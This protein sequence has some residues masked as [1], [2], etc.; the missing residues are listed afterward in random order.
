MLKTEAVVFDLDG[1][2]I[3]S[4]A[5]IYYAVLKTF[6]KLGRKVNVPEKEFYALLGHH[7]KDMFD[8]LNIEVDDI[9][10]FIY[11]YKNLYFEFINHSKPYDGVEETLKAIKQKGSKIAL[12]TTKGQDQ[13]EKILD[14]FNYSKYF[15]MILGRRPGIGI[16]PSAEPYLFICNE[17]NVAPGKT[18]MVGDSELD[19]QCG[20]NAGAKTCAVTFGYRTVEELKKVNPDF[21]IN[22]IRTV[23]NILEQLNRN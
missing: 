12:L 6:N 5:N 11:V 9:E 2:L 4:H 10:N 18:L 15:D 16:K 17:I 1:T 19:I 8:E 22:D 14:Y 3:S 20:K 13:A 23:I 7:F 21:L